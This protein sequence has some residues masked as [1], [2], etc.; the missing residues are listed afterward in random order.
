MGTH[1][2]P[3]GRQANPCHCFQNS[4]ECKIIFYFTLFTSCLSPQRLGQDRQLALVNYKSYS[5]EACRTTIWFV[6]H[7]LY[8]SPAVRAFLL[9]TSNACQDFR[10]SEL[11]INL[12]IQQKAHEKGTLSRKGFV[13]LHKFSIIHTN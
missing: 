2:V 10:Q 9:I 5:I 3:K 4:L 1:E 11:L 7:A 12:N 13:T 6:R 8:R